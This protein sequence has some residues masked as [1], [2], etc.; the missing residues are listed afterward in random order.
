MKLLKKFNYLLGAMALA[1]SIQS[2]TNIDDELEYA[3][4]DKP[5]IS[6]ESTNITVNEGDDIVLNF[7]ADKAINQDMTFKVE[8]VADG[9]D[10]YDVIFNVADDEVAGGLT[11]A[12][13][14]QVAWG[15]DGYSFNFPAYQTAY[16]VTLGTTVMDLI[17]EGVETFQVKILSMGNKQGLVDASSEYITVNINDVNSFEPYQA[18]DTLEVTLNWISPNGGDDYDFDIEV[19]DSSFGFYDYSYYDH[20][21]K[22]VFDSSTPDDTYFVLVEFYS[23]MGNDQEGYIPVR[24]TFTKPGYFTQSV[25][26]DDV[27]NTDLGGAD[28]GNDDYYII[29]YVTKSG[30]QYTIEDD[31]GVIAEGRQAAIAKILAAKAGRKSVVINK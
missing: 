16:S 9:I 24:T 5:V 27:F 10:A 13:F 26:A 23:A 11:Y 6:A 31:N 25:Y 4:V 20:P 22:V 30:N 14:S 29:Y 1:L 12:Y 17:P 21:E 19:Y 15:A 18:E 2:C 7:T 3:S 28:D 8:I